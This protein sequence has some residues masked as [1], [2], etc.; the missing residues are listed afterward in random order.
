MRKGERGKCLERSMGIKENEGCILGSGHDGIERGEVDVFLEVGLNGIHYYI[1][2]CM[3]RL[4]P[5]SF[6]CIGI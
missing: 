3:G 2:D 1:H 6:A 4:Y 5:G